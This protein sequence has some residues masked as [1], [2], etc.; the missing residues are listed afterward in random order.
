ALLVLAM[1][2]SLWVERS[3]FGLALN[4]LKQNEAAAEAAG[5]DTLA[6][7]LKAIMISGAMAAAAGGVYAVR[8]LIV[9]PATVVGML[10]SP[11]AS[12]SPRSAAPPRAGARSSVRSS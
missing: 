11:R 8:L 6:W 4:A 2:V 10:T 12:S 3:R 9:T 7:K 1:L 5:I